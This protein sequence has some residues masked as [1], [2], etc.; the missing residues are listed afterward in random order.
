MSKVSKYP[1]GYYDVTE[2]VPP[3]RN[4]RYEDQRHI[5]RAALLYR[6]FMAEILQVRNT[7]AVLD[8]IRRNMYTTEDTLHEYVAAIP[9][10]KEA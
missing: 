7:D 6:L 5:N 8:R 10:E 3:Q 1:Q 2:E 4:P 9:R